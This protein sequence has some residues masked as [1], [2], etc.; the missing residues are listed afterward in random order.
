MK[1]RFR[2]RQFQ[3]DAATAVCEAFAGQLFDAPTYMIDRGLGQKS[4]DDA[5]KFTALTTRPQQSA[6]I[7]F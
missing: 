4:L 5:K 3:S 1:L 2:H 7:R 6:T